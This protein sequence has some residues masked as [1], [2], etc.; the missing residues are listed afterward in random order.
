MTFSPIEARR[1]ATRITRALERQLLAA[2]QSPALLAARFD[3]WK[4]QGEYS[5]YHFGKDGAY[6][7]PLHGVLRHVHLL[8]Q[9]DAAAL[10]AWNRAWARRARK[11]SDR[12]LVYASDSTQGHLLIFILNEPDAHRIA[13]METPAD[14]T[15][16]RKL[17]KVAQSFVHDGSVIA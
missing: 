4:A 3:Q 8:P 14:A 1:L 5:S 7:P 6:G 17:T 12:A 13:R 16:M 15:R 10:V 9:A 11:V 2:G